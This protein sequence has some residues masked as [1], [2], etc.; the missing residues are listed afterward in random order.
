[1]QRFYDNYLI[2]NM[3]RLNR[4]QAQLWMLNTWKKNRSAS[5]STRLTPKRTGVESV[6]TP[7]EYWAAFVLSATGG[8]HGNALTALT[9]TFTRSPRNEGRS[10]ER[11]A[12]SDRFL[13]VQSHCVVPTTD[14]RAPDRGGGSIRATGRARGGE[15]AARQGR[16]DWPGPSP[17][18][19]TL[20]IERT[21]RGPEHGEVVTTMELL[22][23]LM[24]CN[25]DFARAEAC[26][27]I[28]CPPDEAIGREELA[29]HRRPIRPR[30]HPTAERLSKADREQLDEANAAHGQGDRQQ[31][32]RQ[33]P[34]GRRICRAG[35]GN[36]RSSSGQDNRHT[37][38]SAAWAG[39][40]LLDAKRYK[41]ASPYVEQALATRKKVLG[42]H[43]L[44]ATFSP[45][46]A[47]FGLA[48]SILRGFGRILN[49]P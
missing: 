49:R 19:K 16:G 30:G 17:L 2:K 29:R 21:V 40:L 11:D 36:S 14:R 25:N 1:M 46:W 3:S 39:E 27:G 10:H 13:G 34:G 33:V 24:T 15:Q 12:V 23:D 22:A 9:T 45:I 37:A 48:Y 6:R 31:D 43:P 26:G 28:A 5:R 42:D 18:S 41:K 38:F 20:A 7:P 4:S 32:L 44:V 8:K 35:S 47:S